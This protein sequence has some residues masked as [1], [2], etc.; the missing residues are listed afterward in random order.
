MDKIVGSIQALS[1][2]EQDLKQLKTLLNK[3][4][5]VLLKSLPILDEVLNALDPGVHSLGYVFVLAAKASSQKIDPQKF[6]NQVFRFLMSCTPQQIRMAPLKFSQVCRRFK[7]MCVEGNQAM[8]A[9]KPLITA[10]KK[11]RTGSEVLTP[12]HCDLF[13][14]CLLS[15]CNSVAVPFLEPVFDVNQE[16]TGVTAKDMLLFCYYGGLLLTGLK[17]FPKA[18]TFFKTAVTAPAVVL[19]AIMVESYKKFVLLSLLVHGRVLPL[20]K[21]TS[22]VIQRHH[23]TSFP[24]YHEFA[25]AFSTQNTDE[26]HKIAETYSEVYQKDRNFGLIKQCIQSLYRKNIQRH[27]QT[28]LTFS[29]QDIAASVKLNSP[30]EAERQVLRMIERGEI[31]ATINQKDGMVSF[32]ED[33]EQYDTTKMTNHLDHQI[34]KVIGL[35]NKVRMIDEAIASSTQYLQRTTMHERGGRWGEFDDFEGAEKVLG[36]GPGRL[37]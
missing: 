37:L 9:I 21:Y 35:G 3:E 17:D 31:F 7:D 29:L 1:S 24:Q 20:P 22:S 30:A 10:V 19:S 34:Q 8:R 28:Y 18:L 15:K 13:Q 25:N 2:G 33:P 36:G 27:T 6:M 12:V 16:A 23:K 11:L 5:G 14:V 32:Q 26:V 4:E